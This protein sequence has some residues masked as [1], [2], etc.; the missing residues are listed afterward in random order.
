MIQHYINERRQLMGLGGLLCIAPAFMFCSIGIL[1]VV[2]G[3]RQA[4][5]ALDGLISRVPILQT[6][7]HPLVI[8]GGLFL[9]LVLNV[10]TVAS[11]KF[12]RASGDLTITFSTKGRMLNIV[13]I[14][15]CI[16]FTG[17]VLLYAIGENFII[18]AR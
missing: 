17:T 10:P 3:L 5:E 2:F 18:I 11:E 4:N 16:L 12:D 1:V 7:I 13:V 8:F 6:V 15:S 9:A 14:V